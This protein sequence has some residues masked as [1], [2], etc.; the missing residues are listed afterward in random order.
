MDATTGAATKRTWLLR[1]EDWILAGWIA[2]AAPA[3]IQVQGTSTD[4]FD[5]GRPVDGLIG[6]IA[7]A[8]ALACLALRRP[9]TPSDGGLIGSGAV[10]PFVGGLLLVAISSAT[11]LGLGSTVMLVLAGV[12]AVAAVVIR[13]RLP[14]A[15][16][17][18]R[19]ALVTPYVLVTATLFWRLINAVTGGADLSGGLRSASIADLQAAGPV[20]AFLL[21]FSA[22]YYAMLVFAPRQVAEREGGV[23]TWLVRFAL[24][25]AGFALGLTWLVTLAG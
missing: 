13:L 5:G 14:A 1:V 7:V 24:F 11:A 15:P 22:V 17:I 10:G 19:R 12:I 18:V 6:L 2:L 4:V 8:G 25:V 3:L 23:V 21:A 20:L 16:P 9:T